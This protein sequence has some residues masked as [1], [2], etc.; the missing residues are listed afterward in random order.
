LEGC[1]QGGQGS[2]RAAAP[3]EEKRRRTTTNI[4]ESTTS[5]SHVFP[6]F[7]YFSNPNTFVLVWGREG[8]ITVHLT[9]ISKH[10][11]Y[12]YNCSWG[13]KIHPLCSTK[14]PVCGH[15]SLALCLNLS[16]MNPAY[17]LTPCNNI[18]RYSFIYYAQNI[19]PKLIALT[20]S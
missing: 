6:L 14:V 2:Q 15:D 20:P 1:Y 18:Q 19:V 12:R 9:G 4:G 3:E 11:H 5:S 10:S 17:T 8:V 7:F 16:Q 13:H